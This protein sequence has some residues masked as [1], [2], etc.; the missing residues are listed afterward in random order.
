MIKIINRYMP[1]SLFY[2]GYYDG[3]LAV[4]SPVMMPTVYVHSCKEMFQF[5]RFMCLCSYFQ[6]V[7]F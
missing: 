7:L 4:L 3:C 2:I 6:W 5:D 1:T